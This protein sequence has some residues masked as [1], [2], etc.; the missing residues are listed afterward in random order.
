MRSRVVV[1]EGARAQ[2]AAAVEAHWEMLSLEGRHELFA[3]SSNQPTPNLPPRGRAQRHEHAPRRAD[4]ERPHGEAE[5]AT[6]CSW[7]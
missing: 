5:A 7:Q 6:R 1:R 4:A 2:W 3:P